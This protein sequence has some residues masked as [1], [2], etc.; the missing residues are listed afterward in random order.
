[1]RA[2]KDRTH[3]C[4][5]FCSSILCSSI[6]LLGRVAT[7]L[8][9]R[10]MRG[11]VSVDQSLLVGGVDTSATRGV[12]LHKAPPSVTHP[13]QPCAAPC[14]PPARHWGRRR[15]SVHRL[16]LLHGYGRAATANEPA[17]AAEPTQQRTDSVMPAMCT[18]WLANW[19]GLWRALHSV[20]TNSSAHLRRRLQL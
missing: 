5:R 3:S 6:Q 13:P 1:M 10:V 11:H 17:T 18:T 2:T 19:Q 16:W 4:V 15:G 12:A 14:C 7:M 9:G 8:I 20:A